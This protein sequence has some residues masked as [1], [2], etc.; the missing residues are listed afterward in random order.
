MFGLTLGVFNALGTAVDE[1]AK[2]FN[3]NDMSSSIGAGFI[4]GGIVGSAVY[5]VLLDKYHKFKLT[6]IIIQV[7]SIFA[8]VLFTL[9][10]M[11]ESKTW[12][13]VV[14]FI[15]GALMIPIWPVGVEYCAEITFP[16][17]EDMST[18]M[19]MTAG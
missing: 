4:I 17:E 13:A 3:I 14:A 16:V 12:S 9:V 8:V 1:I 6:L 7:S 2:A 11:Y 5:G 10:L 15:L 18:G 19:I